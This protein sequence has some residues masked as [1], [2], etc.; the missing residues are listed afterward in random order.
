MAGVHSENENEGQISDAREDI[1]GERTICDLAD[2]FKIFGDVTRIRIL[3][4]LHDREM[5]VQE[6]S[7]CVGMSIS[8]VSHQLKTLKSAHLVKS[9][10][11]GKNMHYSLCD[12]HVELVLKTALEHVQEKER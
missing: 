9:A 11:N 4:A 12:E 8:A 10:R 5:C 6:L 7:E 3:W 2:F 1:L